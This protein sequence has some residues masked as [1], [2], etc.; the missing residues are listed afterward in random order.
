VLISLPSGIRQDDRD[1]TLSQMRD[2]IEVPIIRLNYR[3]SRE[4]QYPTPIHDVLAGYDW[5]RENLLLRRSISR[6]GR[7]DHVGKLI[8]GGLAAMLALTECRTGRPGVVA[9]ALRDPAVDWPGLDDADDGADDMTS[10]LLGLRKQLFRKPEQYFDPFASPMLFLRSA[11]RDVPTEPALMD[12][13]AELTLLNRQETARELGFSPPPE[14][15]KPIRKTANRYPSP[16]LGLTLPNFYISATQGLG[17]GSQAEELARRIKQAHRRQVANGVFGVKAL[18]D[19][20]LEEMG[21]EADVR[22]REL[23]MMRKIEYVSDGGDVGGG[24]DQGMVQ[25]LKEELR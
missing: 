6:P 16:S 11:G 2:T 17:L 4:H 25:W 20:E 18:T 1:S 14:A 5:V 8:G 15:A 21:E 7:P 22:A 10:T 24:I 23:G 3:L 19:E 9:A 12:E 13:M